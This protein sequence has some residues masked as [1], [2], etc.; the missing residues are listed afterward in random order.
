MY[1]KLLQQMF[2]SSRPAA[3]QLQLIVHAR[4]LVVHLLQEALALTQRMSCRV[5]NITVAE[6]LVN[7]EEKDG[8]DHH[9]LDILKGF[10]TWS[11]QNRCTYTHSRFIDVHCMMSVAMTTV[12][13][14]K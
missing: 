10:H 12:S 2:S 11:K 14:T 13:L 4:I 1:L 6:V 7:G 3:A 9:I 5:R 8:S